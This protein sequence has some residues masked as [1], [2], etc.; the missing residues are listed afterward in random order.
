MKH[1][2]E[3]EIIKLLNLQP[4]EA[5]GGYFASTYP[6]PGATNPPCSAIYYFLDNTRCS[7]LHKVGSD[8][9]YNFYTGNPVEMLL[10]YPRGHT[11]ATEVCTFGNNLAAGELP[12]KVIPAETWLGSRIKYGGRYALM[13]VS[14]APAFNPDNYVI[15][16]RNILI[17]EYPTQEEMIIALTQKPK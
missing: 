17:K 6:L 8:M 9:L 1:L 15:G 4:N 5:E 12:M 14:M 16:D 7:A 3:D 13:G 11:P 2:S 10:L